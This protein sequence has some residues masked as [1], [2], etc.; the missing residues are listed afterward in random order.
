M[1]KP[2][3]CS[4]ILIHSQVYCTCKSLYLTL[5]IVYLTCTTLLTEL[6]NNF[7]R[8]YCIASELVE[9]YHVIAAAPVILEIGMYAT[10]AKTI[11]TTS[12]LALRMLRL[13]KSF[14]VS[15]NLLGPWKLACQKL[16]E[17]LK[18]VSLGRWSDRGECRKD[19]PQDSKIYFLI[20]DNSW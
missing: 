10:A 9:A 2:L 15:P 17:R 6:L 11:K 19:V 4:G 7:T 20:A 12:I 8:I 5:L 18:F 16:C 1:T 3:A 14:P 13:R